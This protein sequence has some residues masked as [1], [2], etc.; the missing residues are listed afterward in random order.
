MYE[1]YIFFHINFIDTYNYCVLELLL[2]TLQRGGIMEESVGYEIKSLDN[3][4]QRVLIKE[5]KSKNS[6]LITPVQAHIIKYLIDNEKVY[7]RDL[8]KEFK[9]RR[10][11]ASGILKT[12]EK[13][14]LIKRIDTKEDARMKQVILTDIGKNKFDQAKNRMRLFEAMLKEGIDE[15]E[16]HMFFKVI[17]N[18]KGNLSK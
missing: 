8:E 17:K 5:A 13:N 18:I 1:K 14:N 9:I 10:S 2:V 12:M 16:L 4:I 11:T 6:I 3:M 7:Q 15:E